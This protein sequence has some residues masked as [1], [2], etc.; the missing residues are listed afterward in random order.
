M[1]I[2]GLPNYGNTCYLNTT[3]QCLF[4]TVP[5]RN[6]VIQYS[7]SNNNKHQH[8]FSIYQGFRCM[9]FKNGMERYSI[10]KEFVLVLDRLSPFKRGKQHDMLE[11]LQ[12]LLECFH[13]V[14]TL[15]YSVYHPHTL[16][17]ELE[18]KAFQNWKTH[19]ENDYSWIVKIFMGQLFSHIQSPLLTTT[20][21]DPFLVMSLSIPVSHGECHLDDCFRLFTS[22][23]LIDSSKERQIHLWKAPLILIVHLKRFDHQNR[24][25]M[26][27]V[28]IPFDWCIP[29]YESPIHHYRL[30]AIGNHIGNTIDHGHYN[31][32]IFD[33]LRQWYRV[34]DE[35]V[36]PVSS[37]EWNSPSNYCLFYHRQSC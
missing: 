16:M 3:L 36:Q 35:L 27:L 34:D 21:F 31:A 18:G 10:I 23:E 1:F 30:Y 33:G 15:S 4:H 9:V 5:L 37:M 29:L 11:V 2:E 28:K 32:L 14:L 17:S 8:A 20:V 24:K 7:F 25:N 19:Y 13:H 26:T 6:V 12:Y 22:K